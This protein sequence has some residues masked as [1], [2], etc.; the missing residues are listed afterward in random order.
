MVITFYMKSEQDY[1]IPIS[2]SAE[3]N[4]LKQGCI[5]EMYSVSTK[6]FDIKDKFVH[7]TS[8]IDVQKIIDEIKFSGDILK[9]LVSLNVDMSEEYSTEDILYDDY[10]IAQQQIVEENQL[11][12]KDLIKFRTQFLPKCVSFT[13]AFLQ[14][15]DSRTKCDECEKSF[16]F[17]KT[18]IV[19]CKDCKEILKI[20]EEGIKK[21]KLS[22]SVIETKLSQIRLLLNSQENQFIQLSEI[23]N[24]INLMQQIIA[25]DSICYDLSLIAKKNQDALSLITEKD[26]DEKEK[27]QQRLLNIL[28]EKK[29]YLIENLAKI[30]KKR[31]IEVSSKRNN[32]HECVKAIHDLRYFFTDNSILDQYKQ[33]KLQ[34]HLKK[35]I[36]LEENNYQLLNQVLF[37]ASRTILKIIDYDS[38]VNMVLN[39][40]KIPMNKLELFHTMSRVKLKDKIKTIALPTNIAMNFTKPL[41]QLVMRGVPL[42]MKNNFLMDQFFDILFESPGISKQSY[43]EYLDLK[44]KE[45]GKISL[46]EIFRF[47]LCFYPI[48]L[49]LL[50]ML[51]DMYQKHPFK[52]GGELSDCDTHINDYQVNDDV[53]L[54]CLEFSKKFYKSVYRNK[55]GCISVL[56]PEVN[57]KQEVYIFKDGHLIQSTNNFETGNS[58]VYSDNTE[59]LHGKECVELIPPEA[60]KSFLQI[61]EQGLEFLNIIQDINSTS[62]FLKE[63]C[64]LKEDMLKHDVSLSEFLRIK[65]IIEEKLKYALEDLKDY[66]SKYLSND[67]DE[68]FFRFQR[69]AKT[70]LLLNDYFTPNSYENTD[71]SSSE[72]RKHFEIHKI[73]EKHNR[74][75]FRE[76]LQ[77]MLGQV[78]DQIFKQ[79]TY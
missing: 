7:K 19:N 41:M 9:S 76:F 71:T 22:E 2:V 62:E 23:S 78:S 49:D 66:V 43:F 40:F 36:E 44:Q 21:E 4:Q 8:E 37:F 70:C 58:I 74:A 73:R 68:K 31:I 25:I 17:N 39:V 75:I 57:G 32:Y 52:L 64:D 18:H 60:F 77:N 20:V 14:Y 1:R 34:D 45:S 61:K 72:M 27:T 54:K 10:L 42:F 69:F 12:L 29:M 56:T 16:V 28:E 15:L 53:C 11:I 6:N 35:F 59:F 3:M 79:L 65:F 63:F 5:N 48:N 13:K 24:L 38:Y 50:S 55:D 33:K 46:E 67:C 51:Y 30:S 26:Q 47:R